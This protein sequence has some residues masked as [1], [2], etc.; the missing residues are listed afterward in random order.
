VARPD[1][2]RLKHT[3]KKTY[4]NKKA[5]TP[6]SSQSNEWEKR[7]EAYTRQDKE[8]GIKREDV[9]GMDD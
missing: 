9:S 7:E 5:T 2:H 1:S 4:S 8:T 6:I 3:T